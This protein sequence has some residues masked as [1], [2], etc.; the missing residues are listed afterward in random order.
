MNISAYRYMD[1]DAASFAPNHAISQ[2][3]SEVNISLIFD[4][5]D[6]TDEQFAVEMIGPNVGDGIKRVDVTIVNNE[7]KTH[8]DVVR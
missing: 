7:R 2:N 6:E 3:T 1:F 5:E 8:I 4:D